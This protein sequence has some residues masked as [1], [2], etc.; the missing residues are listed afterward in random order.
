MSYAWNDLLCGSAWKSNLPV[1]AYFLCL[2]LDDCLSFHMLS[3]PCLLCMCAHT[4]CFYVH[5]THL[6]YL[7]VH[8]CWSVPFSCND[9]L[10]D[11]ARQI[12][13]DVMKIACDHGCFSPTSI[14]KRQTMIDNWLSRGCRMLLTFDDPVYCE[15][16]ALSVFSIQ[17][18]NKFRIQNITH[19]KVHLLTFNIKY[20]VVLTLCLNAW[21]VIFTLI[22][23]H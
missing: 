16:P 19:T 14:T 8:C 1:T 17:T 10:D 9:E 23:I 22:F 2:L 3:S 18:W 13:N 7:Y 21:H 15:Q 12:W 4:L 5:Y 6:L 11:L 20:F